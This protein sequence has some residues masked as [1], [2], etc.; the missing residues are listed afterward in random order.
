VTSLTAVVD[1]DDAR[2][3][4]SG[5]QRR[6]VIHTPDRQRDREDKGG[7]CFAKP[8][9]SSHQQSSATL[10]L[11]SGKPGVGSPGPLRP[12]HHGHSTV[13]PPPGGLQH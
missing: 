13:A 3:K 12:G 11:G 4:R 6:F 1:D 5:D 2:A 8:E 10:A 9:V 7:Y